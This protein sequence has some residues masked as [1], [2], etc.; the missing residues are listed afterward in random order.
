MQYTNIRMMSNQG[1]AYLVLDIDGIEA[2]IP[3]E[4]KALLFHNGFI[5]FNRKKFGPA[6]FPYRHI[7]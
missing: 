2:E 5:L 3:W 1:Y 7:S 6:F 4:Q